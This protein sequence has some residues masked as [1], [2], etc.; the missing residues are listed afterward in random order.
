LQLPV[1]GAFWLAQHKLTRVC[2]IA[3]IKP[4]VAILVGAGRDDH[5]TRLARVHAPHEDVGLD[6]PPLVNEFRHA[7]P[8]ESPKEID[9]RR[10]DGGLVKSNFNLAERLTDAVGARNL[11]AIDERH[12]QPVRISPGQHCLM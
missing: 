6:A 2:V 3:D 12:M 1:L 8:I 4:I 11:V 7:F 9:P 5:P 10:Q